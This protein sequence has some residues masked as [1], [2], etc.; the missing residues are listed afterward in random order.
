MGTTEGEDGR[1]IN[2]N[3]EVLEGGCKKGVRQ[4]GDEVLCAKRAVVAASVD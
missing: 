1:R 4:D 2:G 3:V